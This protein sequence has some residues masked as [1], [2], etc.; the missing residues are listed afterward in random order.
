MTSEADILSMEMLRKLLAIQNEMNEGLQGRLQRIKNRLVELIYQY[1]PQ[2]ADQQARTGTPPETLS[3][4]VLVERIQGLLERGNSTWKPQTTPTMPLAGQPVQ[5]RLKQ[6]EVQVQD[7]EQDKQKL[8]EQLEAARNQLAALQQA[9]G[10]A[11]QAEPVPVP[12]ITQ[13]PT[14]QIPDWFGDWQCSRGYENEERV[15]RL[16][17]QSGLARRPMLVAL[18]QKVYQMGTSS[19]HYSLDRLIERGM[20]EKASPVEKTASI[21]LDLL[22]LT[23]LGQT[24]YR[25]V[26]GLAA[27]ESEYAIFA[28]HSSPEHALLILEAADVL[29]AENYQVLLKDAKNIALETGA[30]VRPD[31][32]ARDPEGKLIFVEVERDTYKGPARVDKW[33]NL[34]AA[35]HGELYIICENYACLCQVRNETNQVLEGMAYS[36]FLTDLRSL[37]GNPGR[38]IAP[39]RNPR[40]GSMWIEKKATT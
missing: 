17:G 10:Q 35:T 18:A 31:L 24:A 21:S 12:A 14:E 19:F 8:M 20:I 4:E 27:A 11:S 13:Q 23:N 22:L 1:A 38:G 29:S 16:L 36:R 40:D 39:K 7:L 2:E 9:S 25:Q 6:L 3:E 34:H 37:R 32:V 28:H 15:I 5:E 33:R 30:Q 26:T